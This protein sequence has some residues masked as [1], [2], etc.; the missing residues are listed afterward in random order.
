[1][2]MSEGGLKGD[3]PTILLF[4]QGAI[5]QPEPE[6]IPER[7]RE[8]HVG[9]GGRQAAAAEEEAPQRLGRVHADGTTVAALPEP[10][11]GMGISLKYT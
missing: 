7:S 9:V 10:V 1:M 2:Q 6:P 8:R 11:S 4:S 5:E 3:L